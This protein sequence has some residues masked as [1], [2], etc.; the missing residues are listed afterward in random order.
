MEA[1]TQYHLIA[2]ATTARIF[3]G[4]LFFF[5]GYD[6]VFGIGMKQVKMTYREGFS[7][8]HIPTALVDLAAWFTSLSEWV[9]GGLLIIGLFQV[10][11][12]YVLGLNLL[13]AATGFGVKQPLWDTKFVFP[14]LALL[15]FLLCIPSAWLKWSLDAWLFNI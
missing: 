10:P 2:A 14:R 15:L 12:L 4:L 3:L 6:A 11:A 1:L 7:G 8:K 9:C 5:Q 13:V